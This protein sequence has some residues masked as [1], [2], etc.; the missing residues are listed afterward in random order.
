MQ[1]AAININIQLIFKDNQREITHGE[2]ILKY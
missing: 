1:Q 2:I